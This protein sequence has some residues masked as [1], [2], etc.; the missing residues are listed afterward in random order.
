MFS[1]FRDRFGAPGIVAVLAL[2]LAVS[3]G[4]F[5]AVNASK[6][7]DTVKCKAKIKGKKAT[8]TCPA[9]QL[10]GAAGPAGPAGSN[11]QAGTA[12]PQGATGPQGPQ[13]PQGPAG[14]NGTNGAAGANG[15]TV[16]NGFGAPNNTLGTN[17]DFYIDTD[18]QEIWGPKAAGSW[19]GTGPTPLKGDP[20]SA[21][22]TLPVG[23]TETGAWALSLN[24]SG[25][26]AA[27]ISF[28]VPLAAVIA[29]GNT[30]LIAATD[31]VPGA[32][33]DGN[34]PAA[35]V[36]NPEAD[37]GHLCVF[38]QAPIFGSSQA[39]PFILKPGAGFNA[40]AG[41]S[42][43]HLVTVGGPA[44]YSGLGTWAVTG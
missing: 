7:G 39:A 19:V 30:H 37:S 38:E 36:A 33:D 4:A 21:G 18:A 11:G 9:D 2:V 43:A 14:T 6:G 20:W 26:G 35:S 42:G 13:G 41:T 40:G 23:S 44:D 17:G 25:N 29:A 1:R 16:L 27:A 5:A 31:P 12:G 24:G 32:C 28:T 15:K 10:A 22:G 34:P 8:V 3:G